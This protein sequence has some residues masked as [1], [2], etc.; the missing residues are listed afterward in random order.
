VRLIWTE[1]AIA[2]LV[3]IRDYI[4]EHNPQASNEIAIRF[5]Q[6]A[7]LLLKHPQLG[8]ATSRQDVRRLVVPQSVYSLIYRLADSDIEIIEVFDGRQRRPRTDIAT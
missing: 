8:I 3:H 4:R 6:L 7:E 2:D 5:I 1:G